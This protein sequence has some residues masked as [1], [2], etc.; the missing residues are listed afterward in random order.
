MKNKFLNIFFI[1]ALVTG[2]NTLNAQAYRTAATE[3]LENN[4][5][6]WLEKKLPPSVITFSNTQ[7]R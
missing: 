3:A 5:K 6:E 2:S 4:G 1:I 7:A